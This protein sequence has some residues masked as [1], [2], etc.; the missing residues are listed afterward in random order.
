MQQI[1]LGYNM[2]LTDHLSIGP[3]VRYNMPENGDDNVSFGVRA[4]VDFTS[5]RKENENTLLGKKAAGDPLKKK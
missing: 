1:G 2:K 4:T 3:E 5:D